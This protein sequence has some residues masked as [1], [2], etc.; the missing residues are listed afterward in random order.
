MRHRVAD[1]IHGAT[2]E[3][4]GVLDETIDRVVAAIAEEIE[5]PSAGAPCSSAELAR[6]PG[7][8]PPRPVAHVKFTGSDQP[9]RRAILSGPRSNSIRPSRVR[10]RDYRLPTFRMYFW[11]S[12]QDREHQIE[13]AGCGR[14][15][16]R[17]RDDRDPAAHWAMGGRYGCAARRANRWRELGRSVDLSP[18]FALGHYT[19]GFVESQQGD[20]QAA[21]DASRLSRR[22]TVRPLQFAMLGRVR[23]RMSAWACCRRPRTGRSRRRQ[24]QCA[25]T[26]PGDCHTMPGARG[27]ARRG[28]RVRDAHYAPGCRANDVEVFLRA[29]RFARRYGEHAATQR[30]P[31]RV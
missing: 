29:F 21:I 5:A 2:D 25:R 8:V 27:A 13:Q 18:N 28:N 9:P 11:V 22:L 14:G 17:E 12:P 23:S 24:A 16:K 10:M 3:A 15:A 31:D 30:A 26:Y 6:R 20:P 1:E 7:S 4:L 19:V